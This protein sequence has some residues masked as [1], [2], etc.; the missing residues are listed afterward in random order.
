MCT[1]PAKNTSSNVPATLVA[2]PGPRV[3]SGMTIWQ[4]E[5][6]ISR[7]LL[8]W[9]A[10]SVVGGALLLF[11]APFQRGVGVQT[12]MWGVIDAA[13]ALF[14]LVSLRRKQQ[15]PEANKPDTLVREAQ[16]LRRLL[17]LN[18]G[19]DVLYIVGGMVVLNGFTTDFAR[20]NG[21]GIILQGG[22]LLL[23][24]TFYALRV[25]RSGVRVSA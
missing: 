6:R 23:F 17:L 1:S 20:G 21:V 3:K 13:I 10:L 18:A 8:L 9:S 7:Q 2:C 16:R 15:R 25:Q 19:L 11:G 22:F 12:L 14:G 5:R 4:L 24:D